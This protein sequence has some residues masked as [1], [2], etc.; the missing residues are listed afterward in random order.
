[1]IAKTVTQL[2]SDLQI[3]ASTSRPHVSNDC[4]DRLYAIPSRV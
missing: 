2:L 1:M 4:D 3:K